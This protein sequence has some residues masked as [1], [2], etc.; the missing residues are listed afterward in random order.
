MGVWYE[1]KRE[2]AVESGNAILFVTSL[3]VLG[4]YIVVRPLNLVLSEDI[5][6]M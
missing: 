2:I 3:S 5:L 4:G 1:H 6:H